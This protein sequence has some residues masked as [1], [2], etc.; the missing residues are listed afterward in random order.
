M[1]PILLVATTVACSTVKRMIAPDR[2]FPNS[3][4]SDAVH[5]S[6]NTLWTWLLDPASNRES[7]QSFLK[8]VPTDRVHAHQV[9]LAS[10][11]TIRRRRIQATTYQSLYRRAILTVLLDSDRIEIECRNVPYDLRSMRNRNRST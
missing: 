2:S 6:C 4:N 10:R 3:P 8:F 1:V 11:R 7:R 9:I 5:I